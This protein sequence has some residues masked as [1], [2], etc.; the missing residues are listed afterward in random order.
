VGINIFLIVI[1]GGTGSMWG[2]VIGSA[3]VV[4]LPAAFESIAKYS[5]VAFAGVLLVVIFLMPRGF[6]GL[7]DTARRLWS[8]VGP[9]TGGAAPPAVT[10]PVAPATVTTAAATGEGGTT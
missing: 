4:A 7:A 3:V 8:R 9:G 5:A 6:V 2:A 10:S 1:L